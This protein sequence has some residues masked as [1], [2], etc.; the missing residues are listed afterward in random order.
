MNMGDNN[1]RSMEGYE[2]DEI[3]GRPMPDFLTPGT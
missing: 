3:I 1:M 2:P